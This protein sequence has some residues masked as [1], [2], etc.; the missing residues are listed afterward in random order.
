M[1]TNVG[2]I[3]FQHPGIEDDGEEDVEGEQQDRRG[4]QLIRFHP[5]R[6]G[7]QRRGR[8]DHAEYTDAMMRY[9]VQKRRSTSLSEDCLK[10]LLVDPN[11]MLR[12][13]CGAASAVK[14]M[15]RQS[16]EEDCHGRSVADGL[17]CRMAERGYDQNERGP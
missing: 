10:S 13:A 4:E 2:H 11:V 9:T 7:D 1:L 16:T 15:V 17:Q 12:R 8:H 6:E 3:L 14:N 5:P